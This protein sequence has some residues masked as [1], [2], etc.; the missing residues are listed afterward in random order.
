MKACPSQ[1]RKVMLVQDVELVFQLDVELNCV[2]EEQ[3]P[4]LLLAPTMVHGSW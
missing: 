3:I 1:Q 4:L 2:R